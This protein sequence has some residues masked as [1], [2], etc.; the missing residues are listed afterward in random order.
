MS[1]KVIS[2]KVQAFHANL[3]AIRTYHPYLT[4]REAITL[5]S[6]NTV[7]DGYPGPVIGSD[8]D[9]QWVLTK[10]KIREMPAKASS[11]EWDMIPFSFKLDDFD[12]K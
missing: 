10:V 8:E 6:L 1:K 4:M 9:I 2:A 12:L 7:I 5:A 11:V 3:S